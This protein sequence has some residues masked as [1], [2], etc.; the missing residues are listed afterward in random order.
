MSALRDMQQSFL[1]HLLGQP[2]NAVNSIRSTPEAS[3][4]QRLDIY[5]AGY[6]LR[7]KE[8][9]E[10]DYE[11]L[12]AYLGD[13]LFDQ[14]M[15]AY[16]DRYPSHST[17][18]RHFGQHM[19]E[20]LGTLA[21]FCNVPVLQEIGRIEQAFNHSFDAADSDPLHADILS[22]V[23]AAQWPSLRLGFHDSLTLLAVEYNSFPIWRALSQGEQP[24][25]VV[26][27]PGLWVVWR[28]D[29]ISRYRAL[30]DDEAGALETARSGGTFATVCE[31][32]L[33]DHPPDEVPLRAVTL[34]RSWI[35]DQ[36][37][38]AVHLD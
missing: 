33:D 1:G 35:A 14:L 18:L 21:P 38:D 29:L 25:E 24:P 16:I 7:L 2:G 22:S 4:Q 23:S 15:N 6:R 27:D 31:G 11:R 12:H 34:L 30:E 19:Q 32:L 10:T 20:L 37:V 13:D 26:C 28:H 8:A 9:L 3:A 5:A 36:M 17:S